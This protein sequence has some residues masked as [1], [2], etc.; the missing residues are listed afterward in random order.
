MTY[1]ETVYIPCSKAFGWRFQMIYVSRLLPHQF[2]IM[3]CW[4]Y[5][6][7]GFMN[8]V[9]AMIVG[10]TIHIQRLMMTSSGIKVVLNIWFMGVTVFVKL[11]GRPLRCLIHIGSDFRKLFEGGGEGLKNRTQKTNSVAFSPQ[12]NYTDWATAT[13]L[14][15]LVPTFVN[16]GV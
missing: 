7:A 13:G 16:R 15:N 3:L 12:A 6:R 5:C 1:G 8:F 11:I 4:C 2:Q 14:R 10:S 9:V